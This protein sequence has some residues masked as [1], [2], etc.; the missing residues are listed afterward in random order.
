[1]PAAQVSVTAVRRAAA[2]DAH[3]QIYC[4]AH[5]AIA[6]HLLMLSLTMPAPLR[7]CAPR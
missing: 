6:R 3:S 4:R 2:V 7:D 1:M 5:D